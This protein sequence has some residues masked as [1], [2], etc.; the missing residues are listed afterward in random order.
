MGKKEL[1]KRKKPIIFTCIMWI[2]GIASVYP[3]L[4]MVIIS[5]RNQGDIYERLF[6]KV[7]LTFS[8]YKQV[9]NT[10]YFINWYWNTIRTVGISIIF[11]LIVTIPAS[12]AFARMKFKGSNLILGVLLATM[13]VPN[14][15]TMVSRYLYFKSLH[16]LNSSLS[17]ILPETAEVFYL[18]ILIE[19]FRSIPESFV[20]AAK[21][22]GANH[23]K[24]LVSVFVP[25]SGPALATVVLFSFI[26]IW[27]NFMDPFLFINNTAKQLLTPA[28][29]F[30]Q[31]SG[32]ANVPM[33]L[34]AA[35][36]SV[37]PIIIL[38]VFTQKYFI[39]GVSSSGIKD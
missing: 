13:M 18:L 28:L 31:S 6:S 23:L 22:D 34:A 36:L 10:K 12:Y 35:T 4:M 37:I 27:N 33:Q 8:N 3:F 38:F 17:I 19:F 30:F 21:M 9:L 14:E 32:G 16:I 26:N 15:A 20:E 25:L 11:R 5:L 29:K 24:I 7:S 39:A 2:L 1:N